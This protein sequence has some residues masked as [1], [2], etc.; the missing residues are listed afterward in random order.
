MMRLAI[1]LSGFAVSAALGPCAAAMAQQELT[2][3]LPKVEAPAAEGFVDFGLEVAVGGR[4]R[5]VVQ[6][7]PSQGG[8][9]VVWVEDYVGNPDGRTYDI[10]GPL[11]VAASVD[12]VECSGSPL[13]RGPR[14][15]RVHW[16]GGP[17][18]L[19]AVRFSLMRRHAHT[20]TA[21]VQRTQGEQ[22]VLVWSDEF[23]GEGAPDPAK[24]THDLG[25]WGWGNRELQYYTD[26]SKDN[27]RREGGH[28][29]IEARRDGAGAWTSAR[30]TTRGKVSFLYGRVEIRAMVP[31][32]DGMWAAGWLLGDAYRDEKSWPYCGEIDVLEGVG[33]E[34]D[35]TTGDGT[36]H[37]SCHT[38]AYYFKQGNHISSRTQVAGMGTSFHDYVLEWWPDRITVAVDGE[39]YY[40]YDKTDGPL[41]WPFDTP[42]NLILNLAVGGGMGGPV[43]EGLQRQRY[44]IDHVRVYGR[45]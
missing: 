17:L 10:T 27:A 12:A 30:L 37:A 18:Q 3:A 42:Q 25:N 35:D 20:P 21:M 45:Q 6:V 40:V 39:Q 15:M 13:D 16:S 4:Y 28:L 36:N 22:W 8:T 1:R 33:K 44:V 43:A 34:I 32:G 24:W 31:A 9:A 41:E 14:R 11:P 38:R 26:A 29:I 5:C 19:R 2:V 23:D 7:A